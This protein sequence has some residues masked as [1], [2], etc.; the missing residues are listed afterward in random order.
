M[1][2]TLRNVESAFLTKRTANARTKQSLRFTGSPLGLGNLICN[3]G[4]LEE[5]LREARIIGQR[6]KD[7][8]PEPPEGVQMHTQAF[9]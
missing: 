8:S 4:G 2:W 3:I 1:T 5:G 9:I 7:K 6:K